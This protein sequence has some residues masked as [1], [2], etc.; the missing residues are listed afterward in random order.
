LN[1][2]DGFFAGFE[3]FLMVFSCFLTVLNTLIFSLKMGV[4]CQVRRAKFLK[5]VAT[6]G[7]KFI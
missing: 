6:E 4:I 2:F 7:Q 5:K 3:R 1:G